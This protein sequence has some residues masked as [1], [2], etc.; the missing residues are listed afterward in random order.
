MSGGDLLMRNDNGK[1][2]W[3]LVE[4]RG[5]ITAFH[6]VVCAFYRV[7]LGIRSVR[8]PSTSRIQGGARRRM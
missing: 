6:C 3:V 1:A 5:V 8:S 2:G 7:K 4:A